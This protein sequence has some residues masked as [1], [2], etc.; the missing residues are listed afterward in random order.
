MI[1]KMW[2]KGVRRLSRW[3]DDALRVC[4]R[5]GSFSSHRGQDNREMSTIEVVMSKGSFK[6]D[7]WHN[8]RS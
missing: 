6:S 3:L 7:Y 4:L 5:A 2:M 8:E 1:V